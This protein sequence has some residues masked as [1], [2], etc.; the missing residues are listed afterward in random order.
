MNIEVFEDDMTR[1]DIP[2]IPP[3]EGAR[4]IFLVEDKVCLI[5]VK[6]YDLYTLPGGGIEPDETK[7]VALVREIKEET[8]YKV[9]SYKHTMTLKEYFKD[10]IWF[11]HFF[12]VTVDK[13]AE[14]VQLTKEES[15]LGHSVVFK[16]IDEVLELL[17]N[18]QGNHPH[19]ANIHQ[20]EFL[21]LIHSL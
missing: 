13:S 2:N 20:R 16:P 6:A 9:K 1:H 15:A 11:H 18:H 7:E 14:A 19:A 5:H 10:S 21:G 12:F 3:R 8:G 17:Q 4:A